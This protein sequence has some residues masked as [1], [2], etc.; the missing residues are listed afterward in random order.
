MKY[1]QS[2]ETIQIFESEDWKEKYRKLSLC[3]IDII[4]RKLS[5]QGVTTLILDEDLKLYYRK[6]VMY[7]SGDPRFQDFSITTKTGKKIPYQLRKSLL[8]IGDC[9]RSKTF[10]M[11]HVMNEFCN[12]FYPQNSYRCYNSFDIVKDFSENSLKATKQFEKSRKSVGDFDDTRFFNIYIDEVGA[13][14]KTLNNFGTKLTPITT[15]LYERYNVWKT[16]ETK[17]HISTNLTIAEFGT[18]YD[19]RIQDRLYEMFNIIHVP[20]E[21]I[22]SLI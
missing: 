5:K 2:N 21:S 20:G 11:E 15:V 4:K 16:F 14:T 9:G 19:K 13:E 22:R 8:I 12:R 18:I 7:F 10:M 1:S 3:T 17:T 6:L